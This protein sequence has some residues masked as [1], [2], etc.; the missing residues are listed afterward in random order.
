MDV[1]I[2]GGTRFLG[3]ALAREMVSRGFCVTLFHRGQ[4]QAPLPHAVTHLLGDARK[5]GTVEACLEAHRY[6]A[7][8]DTILHA[9]DLE[10]L[11]PVAQRH[12]GQ[13]LHCGST[14]VYAPMPHC[15]AR[16]GDVTPCPP[17]LGGFGAKLNQDHVLMEFHAQTK[18]KVC[19][20]RISNVFGAGDVP[21][22]LWGARDPGFFQRVA[23]GKEVWVP[24]DGRTLLQPVHVDD[25]ARGFCAA[26]EHPVAAGQIYNLSSDR[27]V[28]L[29]HYAEIIRALLC[30]QSPIRHASVEEILAT[31]KANEAGLRFA[32]EH[33]SIDWRK[34]HW[35]LGY[36]PHISVREGLRDSLGWMIEQGLI[37]GNLAE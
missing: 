6:D 23:D 35:D 9:E 13:W 29:T 10:R 25:L 34:A 7:V 33:M 16:E 30:S 17:E 32:C 18:Y 14:G 28:T 19:S 11:L 15:P 26:L 37:Q 27:A 3:A 36:S 31:G 1:L 5:A 8:V 12:A 21:L 24:L 20:L 4:T 2:I 22:D